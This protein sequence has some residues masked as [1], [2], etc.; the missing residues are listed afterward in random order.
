MFASKSTILSDGYHSFI[1]S[2]IYIYR[3]LGKSFL[4]RFDVFLEFNSVTSL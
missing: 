3:Q 1:N 2:P 4:F